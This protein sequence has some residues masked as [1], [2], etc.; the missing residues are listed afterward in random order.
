MNDISEKDRRL[1]VNIETTY[2]DEKR[3]GGLVPTDYKSS[4]HFPTPTDEVLIDI[5]DHFFELC[6]N[7]DIKINRL[8]VK[9]E[10]RSTNLIQNTFGFTVEPGCSGFTEEEITLLKQ[11]ANIFK[12]Q[13][14]SFLIK[15]GHKGFIM[16]IEISLDEPRKSAG[17]GHCPV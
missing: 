12:D 2:D 1:R 6:F 9:S 11:R 8:R 13:F 14:T 17:G 16:K 15:S 7:R 3:P 10:E 5:M 4:E